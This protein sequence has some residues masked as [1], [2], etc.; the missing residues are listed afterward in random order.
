MNEHEPPSD[1][2]ELDSASEILSDAIGNL[3]NQPEIAKSIGGFINAVAAKKAEEPAIV[4]T[5]MV[6]GLIFSFLIFV[7]IGVLAWF[8]IISGE[9]TTGL[10]GALVG[11]WFGQRQASK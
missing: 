11:Y 9:A 5:S 2:V 10:L 8:K 4:K 6:L 3:L 1:E 7:G